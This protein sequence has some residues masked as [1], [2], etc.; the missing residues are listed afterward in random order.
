MTISA[1][2][3]R[4]GVDF[5]GRQRFNASELNQLVDAATP[6]ASRG[7]IVVSTDTWSGTASVPDIPTGAKYYNYIWKRIKVDGASQPTEVLTYVWDE[8]TASDDIQLSGTH[9]RIT[10]ASE[11]ERLVNLYLQENFTV[12]IDQTR[13]TED[14]N[15]D[16]E[17]AR[18]RSQGVLP[19]QSLATADQVIDV[20]LYGYI[21]DGNEHPLSERF[22]SLTEIQAAY[23]LT[24]SYY[25]TSA[26][27]AIAITDQI[28]WIAIQEACLTAYGRTNRSSIIFVP[29]SHGIL[30][31]SVFVLSGA[32]LQGNQFQAPCAG[33]TDSPTNYTELV[34]GTVLDWILD[35]S[36][37]QNCYLGQAGGS[38]LIDDD[39]HDPS[40]DYEHTLF[41]ARISSNLDG[42]TNKSYVR[43]SCIVLAG[44]GCSAG[45]LSVFYRDQYDTSRS[46]TILYVCAPAILLGFATSLF[47]V[48][49]YNCYVG[50]RGTSNGIGLNY[51]SNIHIMSIHR[52]IVL[53]FSGL[54]SFWH[55]ISMYFDTGIMAYKYPYPD[56]TTAKTFNYLYDSPI[57]HRIREGCSLLLGNVDGFVASNLVTWGVYEGLWSVSTW[58]DLTNI[59]ID[60]ACQ[61]IHISANKFCNLANISINTHVNWGWGTF[62]DIPYRTLT[63]LPMW[64]RRT[65]GW[66][67]GN[68]PQLWLNPGTNGISITGLTIVGPAT[69]AI[70]IHAGFP[71]TKVVIDGLNLRDNN[72]YGSTAEPGVQGSHIWVSHEF[73]GKLVINGTLDW[74]A[75]VC[76]KETVTEYDT[77]TIN[78]KEFPRT[79]YEIFSGKYGY[80][81]PLF[82]QPY[83]AYYASYVPNSYNAL[84]SQV[85]ASSGRVFQVYQ[86]LNPDG[87][88]GSSEPAAFASAAL[89]DIIT[90]NHIEW[91]CIRLTN[92]ATGMNDINNWSVL[93]NA[94]GRY[95][96]IENGIRFIF[97]GSGEVARYH[98]ITYP[99]HPS[100]SGTNHK[101]MVCFEVQAIVDDLRIQGQ[102][103]RLWRST[104]QLVFGI[105]NRWN[106][107]IWMKDLHCPPLQGATA[108]PYGGM[109]VAIPMAFSLGEG[110]RFFFAWNNYTDNTNM[111][112]IGTPPVWTSLTPD[113]EAGYGFADYETYIEVKN[114]KVYWAESNESDNESFYLYGGRV[115]PNS[116]E[117][118][119]RNKS[120]AILYPRDFGGLDYPVVLSPDSPYVPFKRLRNLVLSQHV[121]F[122]DAKQVAGWGWASGYMRIARRD[123]FDRQNFI[124]ATSWHLRM[125]PAAVQRPSG[126]TDSSWTFTDLAKL[127]SDG[128]IETD[129]SV[130]WPQEGTVR[131]ALHSDA[132]RGGHY[133]AGITWSNA[134]TV[135]PRTFLRY[136]YG[137]ITRIYYTSSGG[138][139]AGT[140]PPLLGTAEL[141]THP[142][143]DNTVAWTLVSIDPV[144]ETGNKIA[145]FDRVNS[146]YYPV[147]SRA[148]SA[149]ETRV[150]KCTTAGVSN[151][152][153]PAAIA[154]A[155]QGTSETDGTVTWLIERVLPAIRNDSTGYLL[156]DGA[157]SSDR[158]KLLV[159]TTAGTTASS[160]P[161]SIAN[162]VIGETV[163]DGTASWIVAEVGAGYWTKN[164]DYT[165]GDYI[166]SARSRY[167]FRCL[168]TGI[169]GSGVEPAAFAAAALG[170]QIDEGGVGPLWMRVAEKSETLLSPILV[171]AEFVTEPQNLL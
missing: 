77:V 143:G 101:I 64:Q 118:A 144:W 70:L 47:N 1:Q 126:S 51:V 129:L 152:S 71:Q 171:E 72:R 37:A 67:P 68:H 63:S 48:A 83:Y 25:T 130:T 81:I 80:A 6:G 7:I 91:I 35:N 147:G 55:N 34:K 9:W 17:A 151:S 33:K 36:C 157:V 92:V 4:K 44:P 86:H 149:C 137:G 134:L 139:T 158:T 96:Q 59:I 119:S 3:L 11:I 111:Y 88:C 106:Q 12:T 21:G 30:N 46:K 131:I 146:V 56:F 167:V 8:S 99:I 89:G 85:I 109:R 120:L 28:D 78:G 116:F 150:L 5:T 38:G 168:R 43:R 164:T 29:A 135:Y 170:E 93:S 103:D 18:L 133:C 136:T 114:F 107:I 76:G 122:Q 66:H 22:A 161:A 163:T 132:E 75:V 95:T 69:T 155:A 123:G 65:F 128:F 98:K 110:D 141:L 13:F 140:V 84:N 112:P 14:T 100:V 142:V 154:T 124:A 45:N 60:S 166:Q 165:Y 58:M 127:I 10:N 148:L 74:R 54:E 52:S 159:C 23:P 145:P 50:I 19:V 87:L 16:T 156:A 42:T 26:L 153:E 15:L 97:T 113:I 24:H 121:M 79:G 61:P 31:R 102:V 32:H 105:M 104:K 73:L 62:A 138:V 94:V 53:I 160:E 27:G 57:E 41:T 39:E 162:A 115:R 90:D 20:R 125:L 40:A 108:A 169:S 49:L 82:G 2:D 117:L